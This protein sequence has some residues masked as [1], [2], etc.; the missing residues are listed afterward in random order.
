MTVLYGPDNQPIT[1][2]R[3]DL[4]IRVTLCQYV[5]DPAGGPDRE[6]VDQAGLPLPPLPPEIEPTEQ[7]I[8]VAATLLLR[9]LIPH[10]LMQDAW[11]YLMFG[12]VTEEHPLADGKELP[13]CSFHMT[14]TVDELKR[15]VRTKK[16]VH[17]LKPVSAA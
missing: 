17:F 10:R 14:E 9:E 1:P 16:D 12:C 3:R 8:A 7:S 4:R 6:V 11:R 13:V 2:K 5:P 15:T